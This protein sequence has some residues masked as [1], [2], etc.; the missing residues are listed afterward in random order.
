MNNDGLK[1]NPTQVRHVFGERLLQGIV[2]HGVSA[3]LHDDDLALKPFQ[4][5]QR[6]D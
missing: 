1:S 4:P 3:K 2:Y 5:G 6:F